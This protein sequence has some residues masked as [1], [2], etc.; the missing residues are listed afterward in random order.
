MIITLIGANFG[1]S[2]IGTLT[3]WGITPV[4][5]SGASYSGPAVVDRGASL[6]AT[7]TI[8]DTHELGSDGVTVTMGGTNQIGAYSIAGNVVTISIAS[9]T[10]TVVIK[11]PTK[12][13]VTGDE[14]TGIED[15]SNVVFDFD[16]TQ[17]TLSDYSNLGIFTLPEGTDISGISYDTTYGANLNN[18]LPNGLTL[19][20][21]IDASRA[22]TLE[23]TSLFVTPTN[24]VGNRRAILTGV[25][26]IA[27]LLV[28][29]GT[30]LDK[31]AFQ[32][33]A[34]AHKYVGDGKLIYDAETTYKFVHD[35]QTNITV[36]QNGSQLGKTNVDFTGK[37]FGTVLGVIKGKSTAYIWQD[38]ES[39]KKS[40]LHK[41]KFY[42]N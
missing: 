42:Y 1:S 9:V 15:T 39:G 12:N 16:F 21:P 41:L 25:D 24:L 10:G 40:Y 33:S 34:G 2:N 18:S 29:N 37:S 30:S 26:D 27:P 7:V 20:N 6:S 17:N 28:V 22:W 14:D 4:L 35:G 23:M 13:I 38:V 11:V 36:Y 32:I 31:L 19:V 3:T 5:G 8:A